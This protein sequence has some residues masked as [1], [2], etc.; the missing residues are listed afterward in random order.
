MLPVAMDK[1]SLQEF[2]GEWKI[3]CSAQLSIEISTQLAR[4]RCATT[5]G[6]AGLQ[7]FWIGSYKGS[8]AKTSTPEHGAL[9]RTAV[10]S[11]DHIRARDGH[12][13]SQV[14]GR[15]RCWLA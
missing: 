3:S 8:S 9:S 1:E 13:L 15:I 11:F 4:A 7:R 5:R 10:K 14:L 6:D 2:F 12:E